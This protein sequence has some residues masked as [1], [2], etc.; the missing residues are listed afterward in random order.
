MSRDIEFKVWDKYHKMIWDVYN[1]D[2]LDK[3]V[4]FTQGV[5]RRFDE[6]VFMQYTGLKDING[7]K[8]FEGDRVTFTYGKHYNEPKGLTRTG[9]VV[10][11][12][13]YAAFVVAIDNSKVKINF[14]DVIRI[15]VIG[16]IHDK[17]IK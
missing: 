15:E 9:A 4:L 7:K 3:T 5:T 2:T 17:P 8:I 12:K 13:K 6:V 11:D 16:N 14:R 10:Y 1:I